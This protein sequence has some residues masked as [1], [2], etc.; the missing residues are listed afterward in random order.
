MVKP[1]SQNYCPCC[2][3]TFNRLNCFRDE[4][5]RRCTEIVAIDA[6]QFRNFL[7]QFHP[8]K[9]NRELNKVFIFLFY[10]VFH[11]S[12]SFCDFYCCFVLRKSTY[13]LKQA[14]LLGVFYTFQ[15]DGPLFF[16]PLT[17]FDLLPSPL[18]LEWI[19][20]NEF[21]MTWELFIIT[22]IKSSWQIFFYWKSQMGASRKRCWRRCPSVIEI[23]TLTLS[24][25][26]SQRTGPL[27]RFDKGVAK[28]SPNVK[29]N[30]VWILSYLPFQR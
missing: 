20:L 24:N 19:L 8:C 16:R 15:I 18:K 2:A 23:K 25:L 27:D 5:Q 29:I 12:S 26:L 9:L 7:E 21:K 11:I 10:S 4:W 28:H 22:I 14:S 13:D 30:P 1:F 17:T 6:L 3:F